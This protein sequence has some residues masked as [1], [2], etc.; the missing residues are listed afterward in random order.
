MEDYI[1]YFYDYKVETATTEIKLPGWQRLTNDEIEIYKSG[2]YNSIEKFNDIFCFSNVIDTNLFNIE[3]YKRIKIDLISG[4]SFTRGEQI[5]PDYK[6]RNCLISKGLVERGED[7]IYTNYLDVMHEYED[8]R[9][10]LRNE[11]Y[12]CKNLIDGATTK[13]EIDNINFNYEKGS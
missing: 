12:R 7:P 3:Q 6:Y 13:E 5:I 1:Y 4:E 2:D 10:D 8:L 11:F 9:K